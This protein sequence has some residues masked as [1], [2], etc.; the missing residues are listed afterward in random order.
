MRYATLVNA[1]R[2]CYIDQS[3]SVVVSISAL[4]A[5]SD[6]SQLLVSNRPF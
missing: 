5:R 1:A 3:D 2:E 6:T 4:R